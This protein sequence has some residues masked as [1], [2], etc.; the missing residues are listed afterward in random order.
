MDHTLSEQK[1]AVYAAALPLQIK[2]IHHAIVTFLQYASTRFSAREPFIVLSCSVANLKI[3][4]GGRNS[5]VPNTAR[6]VALITTEYSFR[7]TVWFV[8]KQIIPAARNSAE[9]SSGFQSNAPL[10]AVPSLFF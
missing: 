9:L 7:N 1:K 8:K 6:S 5:V 2:N 10:S 4:F 3:M